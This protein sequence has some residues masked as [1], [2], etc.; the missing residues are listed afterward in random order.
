MAK[1]IFTKMEVLDAILNEGSE[2]SYGNSDYE[3]VDNGG[4]WH[5][6]LFS[7]FYACWCKALMFLTISHDTALHMVNDIISDDSDSKNWV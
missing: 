5:V 7:I 3:V 1:C 6:H 2:N 4:I